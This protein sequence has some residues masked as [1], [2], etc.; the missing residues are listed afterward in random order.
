MTYK[1]YLPHASLQ[2]HVKC[3]W[4]MKR[5]YTPE[6]PAEDVTPDAFIELILNFGAPYRLPIWRTNSGIR[7]RPTSIGISRS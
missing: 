4:M 2:R 3:F 7:I 5:T 6:H 1:E